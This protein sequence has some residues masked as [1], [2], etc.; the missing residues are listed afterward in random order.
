MLRMKKIWFSLKIDTVGKLFFLKI[1]YRKCEITNKFFDL[2]SFTYEAIKGCFTNNSN[3][4][5]QNI[6]GNREVKKIINQV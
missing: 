3:S 1:F 2:H 6:L 4:I 5:S